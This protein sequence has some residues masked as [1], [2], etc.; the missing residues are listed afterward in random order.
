MKRRVEDAPQLC[1]H[2]CVTLDA[3]ASFSPS[4]GPRRAQ[5]LRRHTS[6]LES[7]LTSPPPQE[8][9]SMQDEGSVMDVDEEL[10]ER[11]SR[12]DVVFARSKQL[13]ITYYAHLPVEVRQALR[14]A[15][16][17]PACYGASLWLISATRF[18]PRCILGRC[19]PF[20]WIRTCRICR[21]MFCL[22][23]LPGK[24]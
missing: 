2:S 1:S 6:R 24:H 19:R 10:Y 21:D 12:T 18:R 20:D 4:P 16:E 15:G 8:A 5:R 3:M 11:T 14:T 9:S 23:L 13:V 7:Q 17:L 22:E